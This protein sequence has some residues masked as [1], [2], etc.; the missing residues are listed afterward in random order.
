[1]MSVSLPTQL[2]LTVHDNVRGPGYFSDLCE[3]TRIDKASAA[4][5]TPS[6]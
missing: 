1:M 5:D 4:K 6:C 2:E 3:R